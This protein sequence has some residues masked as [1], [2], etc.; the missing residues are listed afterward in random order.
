MHNADLV[1]IETPEHV[2]FEYELAGVGSR[3]IA[4]M[5]DAVLVF[6]G[7]L[8][9][10]VLLLI[11]P[12]ADPL[13]SGPWIA[14][15]LIVAGFVLLWGYPIFFEIVMKGQTPGKR[16]LGMRV[17]R[18]GGYA[19][20]PPVVIVRNLL[21]IVDFLPGAYFLGMCVM[22]FNR[23]YKRIGDFVAGTMVIR[24]RKAELPAPVKV[25]KLAPGSDDETVAELRR[26]G[27]HRLT[28]EQIQL[29]E[30]FLRRRRSLALE[31][32]QRLA[33]KLADSLSAQLQVSAGH[34]ERFIQS[35]YLAYRR[36]EGDKP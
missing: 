8:G 23:R 1:T 33:R 19:L 22:I 15:L 25:S 7:L 14:A 10:F 27:V 35:V 32:R 4:A 30:D 6:L 2:V 5:I 3:M 20:T 16:S 36:D 31:A 26:S 11:I 34:P 17:I 13:G 28:P 29:I 12:G 9:I 21:R 18:E 24:D